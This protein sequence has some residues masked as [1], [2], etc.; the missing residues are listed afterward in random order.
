MK[1]MSK[2]ERIFCGLACVVIVVL[3]IGILLI[4]F[5][6][7]QEEEEYAKRRTELIEAYQKGTGDERLTAALSLSFGNSYEVLKAEYTDNEA[8]VVLHAVEESTDEVAIR[9]YARDTVTLMSWVFGI[10]DVDKLS[11]TFRHTF[12]DTGGNEIQADAFI[13]GISRE[14]TTDINYEN[15]LDMVWN[16][17]SRLTDRADGYL[18]T[19]ALRE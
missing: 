17:P 14:N 16:D 15:F 11:V 1:K 12:L 4:C 10:P 13:I 7:K 18:I 2:M 5:Q 6:N 19:P 9:D 3:A 8:T